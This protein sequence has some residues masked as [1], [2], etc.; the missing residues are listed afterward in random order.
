MTG[1]PEGDAALGALIVLVL[2]V[3]AVSMGMWAMAVVCSVILI[4]VI[5]GSF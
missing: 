3:L 4:A 5:L 1:P 2:V